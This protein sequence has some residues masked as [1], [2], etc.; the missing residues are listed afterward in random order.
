VVCKTTK[1]L[2]DELKRIAPEVE[3]LIET[4]QIKLEMLKYPRVPNGVEVIP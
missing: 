1:H 2:I 3:K 4:K